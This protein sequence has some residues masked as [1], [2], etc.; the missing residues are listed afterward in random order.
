MTRRSFLRGRPGRVPFRPPWALPETDF[1]ARCTACGDCVS[2]CPTGLLK[3][4]PGTF[5]YADFAAATCD[6]CGR[7][8]DA[9]QPAALVRGAGRP[10]NLT[11]VIDD[12]C[13]ARRAVVCR[14]CG[15]QCDAGA[16]RFSPVLGGVARPEIDIERC[17]GCSDCLAG[18][19]THAI[20]I[21]RAPALREN[22]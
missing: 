2:A 17:T 19:P 10:W 6:F 22:A 8:A 16:I 4:S 21:A 11:A 1:A 7:C 9:C 15:E 20:A 13:L 12:A 18:C 14:T 5:P 3:Q